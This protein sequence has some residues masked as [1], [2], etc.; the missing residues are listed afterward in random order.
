MNSWIK[1]KFGYIVL[2]KENLYL[3]NTGNGVELRNLKAKPT[4]PPY[5]QRISDSKEFRY[6]LGLIGIFSLFIYHTFSVSLFSF[7]SIIIGIGVIYNVY[8]YMR[9]GFGPSYRIPKDH[10]QHIDMDRKYPIIQFVDGLG[11]EQEMQIIGMEAKGHEI[12]IQY[13]EELNDE[14]NS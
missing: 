9:E 4:N 2:D 8:L 6:I 3:T 12:L 11:I 14:I 13:W 5:K 7:L 10:I 1:Y